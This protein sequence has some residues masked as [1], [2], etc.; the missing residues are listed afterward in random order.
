MIPPASH[1]V[2]VYPGINLGTTIK[3]ILG[4]SAVQSLCDGRTLEELRSRLSEIE[5]K[6]RTSAGTDRQLRALNREK[7][8]LLQAV[9]N[10]EIADG[11]TNG[12]VFP[13]IEHRQEQ[14]ICRFVP[15]SDNKRQI[16]KARAYTGKILRSSTR[17][18]P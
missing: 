8:R 13:Y 3:A 4:D 2:R 5:Q 15:S 14:M 7:R 17:A 1:S 6:I 11:F 18:S 9:R 12:S 16:R 10:K